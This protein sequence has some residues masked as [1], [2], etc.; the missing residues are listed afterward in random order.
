MARYSRSPDERCVVCGNL[1]PPGRYSYCSPECAKIHNKF[2]WR[3]HWKAKQDIAEKQK[4]V[5][6]DHI[7]KRQKCKG[8]IW[9]SPGHK[10]CVMPSCFRAKGIGYEE[11]D[12][13]LAAM[14]SDS[15]DL[16]RTEPGTGRV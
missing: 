13:D 14:V 9:K 4:E 1:L 11:S 16:Q 5:R 6:M 3:S 2:G 10:Y 8:C 15:T 12:T 7:R